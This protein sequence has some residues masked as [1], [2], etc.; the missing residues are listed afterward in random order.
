MNHQPTT[1]SGSDFFEKPDFSY[2]DEFEV[3]RLVYSSPNGHAEIYEARRAL[4]RFAIKTLKEEFRSDPVYAGLLRKEFEIGFRLDHSG[5]VHTYSFE[6]IKGLGMCIVLEWIEGTT[7][8]YYLKSHVPSAEEVSGYVTRLSDI[9]SYLNA[10][11]IVHRDIKPSNLMVTS[12]GKQLK[13]IDFGFAD[14]SEYAVL[15]QS[16]GTKEYAAPEQTSS[17]SDGITHLSD[18]YAVGKILQQIPLPKSKKIQNF[19]ERMVS[20]NPA[21]RPHDLKELTAELTKKS[22]GRKNTIFIAASISFLC[23][24]LVVIILTVIFYSDSTRESTT[25]S[26]EETSPENLVQDTLFATGET[27]L[28]HTE[29]AETAPEESA[30]TALKESDS[31]ADKII[32]N[33]ETDEIKK[34]AGSY[35]GGG[36]IYSDSYPIKME[37]DIKESGHVYARYRNPEDYIWTRMEGR[38][39]RGGWILIT[40]IPDDNADFEM[41]MGFDYRLEDNRLE[42]KGYAEGADGD[43]TVTNIVLGKRP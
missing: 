1:D 13:L 19:V 39:K 26:M 38:V 43:R 14:S 23:I 16:G 41:T 37:M 40:A 42:L 9:L 35:Q 30:A 21:S 32:D 11:G 5:I 18:I 36:Y 25:G 3:I 7:L 24:S 27:L 28:P 15:K 10:R 33:T 8:E 20:D 2:S 22:K 31:D 34:V 12:D 29:S 17:S 6:E 4:K